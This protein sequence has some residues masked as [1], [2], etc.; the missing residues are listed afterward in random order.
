MLRT[1][2]KSKIHYV[3]CTE[4]ELEY[5]ASIIIDRYIMEQA[6]ILEY[7]QVQVLNKSNGER[8]WTYAIKGIKDQFCLNGP[9]ARKFTVG[10]K[11]IILSYAVMNRSINETIEPIIINGK[12]LEKPTPGLTKD[13]YVIVL[14][15]ESQSLMGETGFNENSHLINDYEGLNEYGSSAYFVNKQWLENKKD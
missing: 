12:E 9:S 11:I 10:D 1:L 3:K 2:L 14:W 15:P 5:E 7:E 8:I 13:E 6:N 4:T